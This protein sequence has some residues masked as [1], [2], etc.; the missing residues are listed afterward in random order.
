M[1]DDVR[2]SVGLPHHPK[3]KKLRRRVGVEGCWSLIVLFLWVGSE[4]WDGDLEGMSDEDIELAADWEGEPDAFVAAMVEVGFLRG[5]PGKRAVHGWQEHNPYAAGKGARIAKG[6]KAAEARWGK[7]KHAPG[8]DDDATSMPGAS[9]KHAAGTSEQCPP[10]P[11][12]APTFP[13]DRS[14]PP[15]PDKPADRGGSFEGHERPSAPSNPCAPHAIALNRAGVQ[16]TTLNPDLIAF[17]KEG[18]TPEQLVELAQ[19]AEFQGKKST[20]IIRAARRMLT[21]QPAAQKGGGNYAM[22]KTA[23]AIAELE[24]MKSGLDEG[25]DFERVS[26]P[27]LSGPG[28]SAGA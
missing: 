11:A 14:D 22:G 2:I 20:Y 24:G 21:E 9:N 16:V 12:P 13:T 7:R 3:T 4:R 17:E 5:D 27:A 8:I 28:P 26:A 19:Q 18:G 10:A 15:P 6:K 1:A 23:S 25:R